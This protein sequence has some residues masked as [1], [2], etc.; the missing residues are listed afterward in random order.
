MIAAMMEPVLSIVFVN[1]VQGGAHGGCQKLPRAGL[2]R[3]QEGF[4][5]AKGQFNRSE[6]GRVGWQEQAAGPAFFHQFGQVRGLVHA[7]VIQHDHVAGCQRGPQHLVQ[8]HGKGR[9]IDGP[10]QFHHRLDALG[11]EGGN[12]R[13]IGSAAQRHGLVHAPPARGAA[14]AAGVGDA[15]FVH[16]LEPDHVLARKRFGEGAAQLLHPFGTTPGGV[17]TLFLRR[18]SSACKAYQTVVRPATGPS[19]AASSA[20]NSVKRGIGLPGHTGRQV[21]ARGL[22]QKRGRAA[23]VRQRH[24]HAAGALAQFVDEGK[25]NAKAG[26]YLAKRVVSRGTRSGYPFA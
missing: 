12:H 11:R 10:V 16:E 24:Y 23:A 14:V 17:N 25:R 18:K 15:G 19:L 5:L 9:R 22:V 13:H 26:S 6:T 3:A 2:G 7:Q 20:C 1:P 21:G 4:E 8:V